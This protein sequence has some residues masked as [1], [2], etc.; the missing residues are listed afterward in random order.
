M[1]Q[2]H[3]FEAKITPHLATHTLRSY[4]YMIKAVRPKQPMLHKAYM[5]ATCDIQTDK[6]T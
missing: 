5:L 3:K 6:Q 1:S 4:K 2:V